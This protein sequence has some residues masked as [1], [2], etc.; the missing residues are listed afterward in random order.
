MPDSSAIDAAI[1]AKLVNDA[2]LASLLPDGVWMDEASQGSTRFVIV[3]LVQEFDQG[4]FGGRAIEDAVYLVKAVEKSASGVNIKAAAARIDV[5][6]EDQ[7]LSAT[8]YTWMST[9]REERVR[10]TEVD[11]IDPSIRWQHRGGRYRIQFSV[12]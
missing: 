12:G 6:L 11:E 4:V 5:L 9:V 1:L 10:F 7:S 2:T 3:S 8:G